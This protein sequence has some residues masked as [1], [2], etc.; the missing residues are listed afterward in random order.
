MENHEYQEEHRWIVECSA[1]V[2]LDYDEGYD[3]HDYMWFSEIRYG[4]CWNRHNTWDD[5]HFESG[6]TRV[7]NYYGL[8]MT[9]YAPYA[10][11]HEVDYTVCMSCDW[12]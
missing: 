12:E 9:D 1:C 5:Y 7:G 2:D 6:C 10:V 8:H 4:L 11:G 3:N